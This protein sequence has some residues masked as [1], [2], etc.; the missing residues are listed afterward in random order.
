MT[1]CPPLATFHCNYFPS[2]HPEHASGAA[3]KLVGCNFNK[4]L[5][6]RGRADHGTLTR[7]RF[8]NQLSRLTRT[9]RHGTEGCG[10]TSG[11]EKGLEEEQIGC[12]A[13]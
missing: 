13:K 8:L 11:R 7:S 4:P 3:T 2:L 12:A 1:L 10:S 5:T 9:L 6:W